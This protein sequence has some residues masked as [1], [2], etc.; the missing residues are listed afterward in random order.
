[1]RKPLLAISAA[2]IAAIAG[3][4]IYLALA[5][6]PAYISPAM[7]NADG[8]DVGGPFEL[9]THTGE[10]VTAATLID[11]PTLVY[12]G[13]TYCPDICPIDVQIMADAVSILDAKGIDVRPVFITIDPARDTV[14]SLAFYAEGMHPKMIALTGAQDEIRAAADAYKVF[15]QRVDM[16][17][18][19]AEYLMNHT[20]YMY[21]MTPGKGITAIFRRNF[22]PEQIA[23]DIEAVLAEL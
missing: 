7:I 1:M 17:D 11:R 3:F 16:P 12:F 19:A 6:S 20:G 9:T 14:E 2:L 21:L 23:A 13:Y 10:R 18:S 22:P 15:Y 4:G 8:A 5:P